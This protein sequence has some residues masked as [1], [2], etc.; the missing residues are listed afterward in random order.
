MLLQRFLRFATSYE[1]A[2]SQATHDPIGYWRNQAKHVRWHTFPSTILSVHDLHFHRWFPNGKIN[3]TEQCLD[4][5]LRD[6][7]SQIAYFY[8][9]PITQQVTII[10]PRGVKSPMGIYIGGC[11]LWLEF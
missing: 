10:L 4:V 9:S 1:T 7:A 2:F 11:S 5:H 3:I 6:R 8:E